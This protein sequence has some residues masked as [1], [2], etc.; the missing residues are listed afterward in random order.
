MPKSKPAG[1][2]N[3]PDKNKRVVPPNAHNK[4]NKKTF[5]PNRQNSK[6]GVC[7]LN[8]KRGN[9][10]E[11]FF[12]LRKYSFRYANLNKQTIEEK[13]PWETMPPCFVP[14]QD[15]PRKNVKCKSLMKSLREREKIHGLKGKFGGEKNPNRGRSSDL[16]ATVTVLLNNRTDKKPKKKVLLKNGYVK[17]IK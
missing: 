1:R 16:L 15:M 9:P 8:K 3:V 13:R 5:S 17:K 14:L 4:G 10:L 2:P 6:P 12:A 11:G 7:W